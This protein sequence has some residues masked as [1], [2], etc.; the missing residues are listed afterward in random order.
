MSK[1]VAAMAATEPAE[2][3]PRGVIIATASTA[4]LEGQVGQTDLNGTTIR[5]DGALRF[6]I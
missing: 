3:G 1:A 6:N 5:I 2:S 4:G